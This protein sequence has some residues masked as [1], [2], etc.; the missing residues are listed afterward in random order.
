MMGGK[1]CQGTYIYKGKRCEFTGYKNVACVSKMLSWNG[2][3]Q[4]LPSSGVVVSLYDGGIEI[5]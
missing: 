5:K 2:L 4:N 3:Y 1:K